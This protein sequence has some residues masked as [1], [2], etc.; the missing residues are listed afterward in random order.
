MTK[1]STVGGPSGTWR[2]AAGGGREGIE[3]IR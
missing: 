3:G 2:N 1:Q